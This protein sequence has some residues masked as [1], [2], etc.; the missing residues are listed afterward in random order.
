[1]DR[2]TA[3]LSS[4][5]LSY[6]LPFLYLLTSIA[7]YL[8]TYDSAQVKITIVQM[9]G[10]AVAGFWYLRL[11]S[12][13]EVPFRSYLPV[14]APLLA[15]LASGLLS[16]THAAYRGPSLDECWRRVFYIHFALIA[17]T[18]INTLQRLKRLTSY[19][20]AATAVSV[21]YGLLELLDCKFFPSPTP[22]IDPFIWRQAFG[23]RI[24]ST[25]GN[26]NF[27]GNFL[28][29][30]TPITLALLLK[31]NRDKPVH[32]LLFSLVTI[33][34]SV[35]L[36][37]SALLMRVIHAES[38]DSTFFIML[39]IG[40]SLWAAYAYSFLGVLFFLVTLCNMATVSKGAWIGYS[41]GYVLYWILVLTFF[42]QFQSEK[43]RRL[44]QR[45][46]VAAAIICVLGV[47]VYSHRRVDS[48]RFR[49]CTWVSTWEMA[50]MHPIWGNGIGSF[51]ILYPAFRRPQIFHIE[52]KHNTETDHAEDEYWEVLQD[53]GLIGFGIFLWVIL[54]F[55]LLG[56]RGL[57]RFTEGFSIRDPGS[58]KRKTI[59]DPRAYYMLAFLASFWGMLIHNF[60]DV[61]LRFVSSGIFLWLLAGLIATMVVHDPLAEKDAPEAA[62]SDRSDAVA[63]WQSSLLWVGR[64]LTL[65]L[66]GALAVVVLQQ[67]N[68]AQ[69]G[70]PD[71]LGEQLQ[72]LIS[73]MALGGTVGAFLWLLY[74]VCLS[75]RWLPAFIPLWLMV[76]PLYT[77]WGYFMADVYHNRGIFFSKQGKWQEAIDNYNR[78]VNLNPNYIMAFYFMGNVYTDRW[79]SGDIDRAMEQY[80]RVWAIAPNYVQSHH[81]AGLVYLKKGSDDRR[82]FDQLRSAGRMQEAAQALE[83]A[84]LDWEQALVF[85]QKYHDI[86]PVFEPNYSRVG[87]V[88]IQLAEL[89]RIKGQ[90]ADAEAYYGKAERAYRE[91]L[92][93]WQCCN[94]QNDV[95][96]EHWGQPPYL[97]NKY[98]SSRAARAPWRGPAFL[99]N[100]R[101]FYGNLLS[102]DWQNRWHVHFS[103]EMWGNLGDVRMMR[104]RY[105][106]AVHA[107]RMAL[108][109]DPNNVRILKNMANA[110]GRLGRTREMTQTWWQV[111]KVAPQDPDVQR[112]FKQVH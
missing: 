50:Q 47:G 73:W 56:V 10:T 54:T 59:D 94:P 19:L 18:E 107:Y 6:G 65:L 111:L 62:A 28:V 96:G 9:M 68:N 110:L 86:D 77:F 112:V 46:I 79:Q 15:S 12:E 24:F 1:M 66:F 101:E 51:R 64:G 40:F 91:S 26:P 53:E 32:L 90:A 38:W 81:Q 34:V 92:Y 30:V 75:I 69:S 4:Q 82:A 105:D 67:F 35:A 37:Q 102:R 36:W 108:V 85:F 83:Q 33:G 23:D 84:R 7:F 60:M 49:I 31:R 11:A 55:S 58:G 104:E 8:H 45:A 29:I 14:V 87:W 27:F 97:A 63:A 43:L 25:F 61:S 76:Y 95:V 99:R 22:G 21:G 93:A 109:Q 89:A 98:A 42:T 72:W 100:I 80:R 103:A 52:G 2:S 74:R 39:L 5:L 20:L 70:F 13:G 16:W 41:A 48:L 3:R 57:D 106:R 44:I 88:E 71:P 78:V 17:I